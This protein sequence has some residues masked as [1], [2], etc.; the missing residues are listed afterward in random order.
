MG[1]IQL[2]V[3]PLVLVAIALGL[4]TAPANA[5]TSSMPNIVS[6][7]YTNEEARVQIVFPEGWEGTEMFSANSVIA[8]VFAD[9]LEAGSSGEIASVIM[10]LVSEKA[11]VEEPSTTKPLRVPEDADVNCNIVSTSDVEAA[12]T[13]G[14]ESIVECTADEKAFKMKTVLVETETQ[15]MMLSLI[16][17]SE[18][19]EENE[20]YYDNSLETLQIGAALDSQDDSGT[21]LDLRTTTHTVMVAGAA[22]VI[23]VRSSST[24]TAFE[25][26]EENKRIS[27]QVDGEAGTEGRTELFMGRILEGPYTVAIDGEITSKFEVT[28][29]ERSGEAILRLSYTHSTHDIAVTGTNVIP[30]FPV[31]VLGSLAAIIGLV[32]LLSRRSK[33]FNNFDNHLL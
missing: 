22:I 15:W 32:V 3:V 10:L 24:V 28:E 20:I 7:I 12:G 16:A 6:G 30:E 31:S 25:I 2:A 9:G 14:S 4:L 19:Y 8:S 13:T 18:E 17:P 5:Q 27:F 23:E 29:N 33:M 11:H 26:D 21:D 1:S